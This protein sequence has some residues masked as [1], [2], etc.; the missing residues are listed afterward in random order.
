MT[1]LLEAD[2]DRLLA[3]I[4]LLLAAIK[5]KDDAAYLVALEKLAANYPSDEIWVDV[6]SR[7]VARK[8]GFDN[9]T[10]GLN[11]FDS[12]AS[13]S[14]DSWLSDQSKVNP[15]HLLIS[16]SQWANPASSS[17]SKPSASWPWLTPRSCTAQRS[18]SSTVRETPPSVSRSISC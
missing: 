1:A 7:G 13:P 10:N 17:R 18:S 3:A 11:G 2:S 12:S 9:N 16:S 14:S 5:Q 4:R 8:P 6:L 15:T